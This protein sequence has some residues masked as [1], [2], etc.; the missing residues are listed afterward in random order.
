MTNPRYCRN[1]DEKYSVQKV[2]MYSLVMLQSSQL[3]KNNPFSAWL[4]IKGAQLHLK[5]LPKGAVYRN[6]YIFGLPADI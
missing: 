2:C 3:I 6:Q 5:K 4:E 1:F